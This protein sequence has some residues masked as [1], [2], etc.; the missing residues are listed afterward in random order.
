VK[1]FFKVFWT[2]L[3]VVSL[4]TVVLLWFLPI[5]APAVIDF[6]VE[7]V[8][9]SKVFFTD[10]ND[11]IGMGM[12][13]LRETTADKY[14][15]DIKV[16]VQETKA[17]LWRVY[18]Q[19]YQK[20][21]IMVPFDKT[22]NAIQNRVVGRTLDLN[23]VS[24]VK[25]ITFKDGQIKVSFGRDIGWSVALDALFI[26]IALFCLLAVANIL[27]KEKKEKEKKSC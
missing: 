10:T 12:F 17:S 18:Y 24:V 5:K 4:I 13:R 8:K 20:E 1:K 14:D 11:P 16:F 21:L 3:T 2:I 7:N 22:D 25:E 27:E 19:S 26:F 9:I 6:P 23:V 15:K